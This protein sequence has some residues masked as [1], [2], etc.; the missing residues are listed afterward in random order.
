MN[1]QNFA[2]V[3]AAFARRRPFRPFAVE[4]HSG[5][6]VR[7]HHPEALT[8]R[9]TLAIF[10]TPAATHVLFD[11]EAVSRVCDEAAI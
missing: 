4:L 6:R 2:L 1:A 8:L 3:V 7:V 9:G 10:V 5:H 11:A